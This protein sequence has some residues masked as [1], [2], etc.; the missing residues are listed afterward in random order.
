VATRWLRCE[1]LSDSGYVVK[2][3]QWTFLFGHQLC[4]TADLQIP[5][6]TLNGFG[7]ANVGGG[8]NES[9]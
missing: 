1:S 6:S 7:F 5:V 9:S 3:E 4:Q 2:Q 8:F